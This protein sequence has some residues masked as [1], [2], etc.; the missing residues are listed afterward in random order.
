MTGQDLMPQRL[1]EY[2]LLDR[3]GEGGMGVVFRALGPGQCPVALKVLRSV[4]AGEPT[5]RRRL[6]REVETMRRVRSPYVAEVIDADLEGELPY[7][8]T[9]YV[10]GRTLD[11]VVASAG[12]RRGPALAQLI[13]GLADALAAIHA[14]GVV[15]RDLKPGNVML[16]EGQPV[17]IDFGI[18]Q[19]AEATRLTLTGMFMGT[20]G[21]L[22]PEVIGGGP[23]SQA[24]DVH[25]WGATVA[26]AATGRPPYGTGAYETIFYRILNGEPDLVG[27]PAPVVPLLAAAMARD[28]ARRPT[29]AELSARAKALDPGSLV[30]AAAPAGPPGPAPVPA[31]TRAD[32]TLAGAGGP[33]VPVAG[34]GVPVAGSGVPVAGPGVPV[35]GPAVPAPST[36]P[37]P[38]PQPADLAGILPP[39]GYPPQLPPRTVPVGG[40]PA[41]L[42]GD[43]AV[44]GT[45]NPVVPGNS[46]P[47]VPAGGDPSGAPTSS[48]P[49]GL[50]RSRALGRWSSVPAA[51]TMAIA[52]SLSVI[53]P[54]AGTL[55]ALAM[56]LALRSTA[57][58][59]RQVVGW[60]LARGARPADPLLALVTFPWFLLR[61]TVTMLLLAPFALAVAAI[62]A[63]VT[64]AADPADWPSRALGY[65]AG[66]LV[67]CYGLG[68]GSGLPRSQLRRVF[69]GMAASR[70]AGAAAAVAMA[71]LAVAALAAALSWPSLYWPTPAPGAAIHLGVIHLRSLHGTGV[72]RPR[73][74]ARRIG[75]LRRLLIRGLG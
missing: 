61:A 57:L 39:A 20:P 50:A 56:I 67:A 13:C 35:A 3:I 2:R 43:P 42:G 65:A 75:L 4:V 27:A 7:V 63:A 30:P 37:L 66:V 32:P 36:R 47:A 55:G 69:A 59:R 41:V 40:D 48:F 68:P 58:A 62:A 53:L 38:L 15:H 9:R 29:A 16:L 11:Q 22:A 49:G 10:P 71:A 21:Y 17:V 64:V 6:A 74:L 26:F 51:A 28:P 1:G 72:L 14:A 18:A 24:S 45:G 44:P 19:G 23:S 52:A 70:A 60:R 54:V 8:V 12:A 33:G 73:G 25:A 5:A 46:A 31:I 34:P